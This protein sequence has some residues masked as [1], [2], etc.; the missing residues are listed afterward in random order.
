MSCGPNDPGGKAGGGQHL[1]GRDGV[2]V[3]EAVKDDDLGEGKGVV[4]SHGVILRP[5]RIAGK[6]Q[7]CH[8]S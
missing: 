8:V 4:L 5:P 3:I 2:E 7:K 6:W 1:E